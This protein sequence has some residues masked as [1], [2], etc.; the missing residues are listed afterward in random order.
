M[1]GLDSIDLQR[2]TVSAL[3]AALLSLVCVLGAVA[4]AHVGPAAFQQEGSIR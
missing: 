1:F 4:P 3:G 2:I